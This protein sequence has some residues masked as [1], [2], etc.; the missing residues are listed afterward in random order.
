MTSRFGH[1]DYRKKGLFKGSTKR[2]STKTQQ[3]D[4]EHNEGFMETPDDLLKR[5]K[6]RDSRVQSALR[7]K[8]EIESKDKAVG[9]FVYGD[10]LDSKKRRQL[11]T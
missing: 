6:K 2:S 4:T 5:R 10:V 9:K 7:D 1:V 11:K 3:S 8:I